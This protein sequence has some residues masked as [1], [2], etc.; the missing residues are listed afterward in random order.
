MRA[1]MAGT[2]ICQEND[3]YRWATS[4]DVGG[5][6][7][8]LLPQLHISDADQKG[9]WKK[10]YEIDDYVFT[11]DNKSINHRPDLWGH[12]GF[13]REIAA[14]LNYKSSRLRIFVVR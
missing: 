3:S 7:E 10:S 1:K 9:V 14:I 13:A 12:R 2:I 5:Q 6:K 4:K 8:M 11:V